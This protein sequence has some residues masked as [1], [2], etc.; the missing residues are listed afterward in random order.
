[1]WRILKQHGVD[2]APQR[3]SVTWTR[4]LRSQAA[5]ACDF[6]TVDTALLRRCYLLFF[7]DITTREVLYGGI[8]TNPTGAWTTQAAATCSCVTHSG[9][10]TRGHFCETAPAS[11]PATSTRSSEPRVSRSCAPRFE[12]QWPTRSPNVGSAPCAESFLTAPSS[13]PTPARTPRHRLHRPLQRPP[14]PPLAQST[15]P[16]ADQ[17]AK[18]QWT[19]AASNHPSDT[20]WRTHQRIPKSRLTSHD[21]VSGTHRRRCLSVEPSSHYYLNQALTRLCAGREAGPELWLD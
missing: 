4:F 16:G 9:S 19:T 12:S 18:R 15:T 10:P 14:A 6:V 3:T 21:R 1:M 17:T 2:P 11:S 20:L 5:V 7:I 8:T 13:G